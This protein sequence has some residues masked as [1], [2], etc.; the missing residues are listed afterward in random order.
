[1]QSLLISLCAMKD[2]Y[3]ILIVFSTQKVFR[4]L[5]S[6]KIVVLY[7]EKLHLHLRSLEV[8]YYWW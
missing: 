8:Y 5:P 3:C 7:L 1:M 6:H 2:T 4:H